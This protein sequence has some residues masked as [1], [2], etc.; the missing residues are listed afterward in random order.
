VEVLLREKLNE[1]RAFGLPL[2]EDLAD[3]ER[4]LD[5]SLSQRT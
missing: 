4:A 3:L 5:M 2:P 1:F